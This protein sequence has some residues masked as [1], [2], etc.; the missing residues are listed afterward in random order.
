M[1]DTRLELTEQPI[2]VVSEQELDTLSW[3]L[4]FLQKYEQKQEQIKRQRAFRFF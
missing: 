3:A 4:N 2:D 1:D